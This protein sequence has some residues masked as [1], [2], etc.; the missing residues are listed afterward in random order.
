MIYSFRGASTIARLGLHWHRAVTGSRLIERVK[1][2]LVLIFGTW[3]TTA[4]EELEQT[5]ENQIVGEP[6]ADILSLAKH[7]LQQRFEAV[8]SRP[9]VADRSSHVEE[10]N[11]TD[12]GTVVI[13]LNFFKKAPGVL[14]GK[15]FEIV[16]VMV[17]ITRISTNTVIFFELRIIQHQLETLP[18]GVYGR[19][20]S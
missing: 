11:I 17:V 19:R 13:V 8:S 5:N 18:V 14:V 12:S 15:R 20:D 2:G 16:S 1:V 7:V 10:R 9:T 4:H 3:N 6:S